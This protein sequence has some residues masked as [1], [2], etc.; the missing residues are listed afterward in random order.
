[1]AVKNTESIGIGKIAVEIITIKM[2]IMPIMSNRVM[3]NA[4]VVIDVMSKILMVVTTEKNW[5]REINTSA[6]TLAKTDTT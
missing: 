6:R 4:T 1:M 3:E 5:A 2:E